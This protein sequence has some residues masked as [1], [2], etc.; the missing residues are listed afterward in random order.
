LLFKHGTETGWRFSSFV[1]LV[2]RYI[3]LFPLHCTCFILHSA[4]QVHCFTCART[5]AKH[6]SQR[7]RLTSLLLFLSPSAKFLHASRLF[8]HTARF[9]KS[10]ATMV[11]LFIKFQTSITQS[12]NSRDCFKVFISMVVLS[13]ISPALSQELPT[14]QSAIQVFSSHLRTL[15][16][17]VQEH[18]YWS[19]ALPVVIHAL[20]FANCAPIREMLAA[21]DKDEKEEEAEAAAAAEE[22]EGRDAQAA[23]RPCTSA[24][25]GS[26]G[27]FEGWEQRGSIAAARSVLS[28][29]RI[30]SSRSLISNGSRLRQNSVVRRQ[31]APSNITPHATVIQEEEED[32]R[33]IWL[34]PASLT[35]QPSE[36]LAII[37]E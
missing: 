1:I 15:M 4:P 20:V 25:K 22:E 2:C 21:R 10:V 37:S 16:I 36:Y 11:C 13:C 34:L 32:E 31:V 23:K 18:W 30:K 5:L 6:I 33:H 29:I 24:S 35:L 27:G 17:S 8:S 26:T 19:Q 7:L 12:P 14:H 28:L 3:T 9:D